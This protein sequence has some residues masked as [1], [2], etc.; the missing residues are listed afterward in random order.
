M[1]VHIYSKKCYICLKIKLHT[2][3]IYYYH[4]EQG[5]CKRYVNCIIESIKPE[6]DNCKPTIF[7]PFLLHTFVTIRIGKSSELYNILYL[8][9]K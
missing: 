7:L 8:K 6:K 2:Y 4:I 1:N 3:L 5:I 9:Y